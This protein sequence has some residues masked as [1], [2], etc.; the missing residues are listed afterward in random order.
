ML[1]YFLVD[2]FKSHNNIP[3]QNFVYNPNFTTILNIFMYQKKYTFINFN[4]KTFCL[5]IINAFHLKYRPYNISQQAYKFSLYLDVLHQHNLH[6][7]LK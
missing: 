5:S 6:N 4:I 2:F 7:H 1:L 3:P